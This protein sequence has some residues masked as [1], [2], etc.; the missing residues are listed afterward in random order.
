MAL[1]DVAVGRARR[2]GKVVRVW[3]RDVPYVFNLLL[4]SCASGRKGGRSGKKKRRTVSRPSEMV[5]TNL[6]VEIRVNEGIVEE[7]WGVSDVCGEKDENVVPMP[8][9]LLL[10]RRSVANRERGGRGFVRSVSP[11]LSAVLP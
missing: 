10:C 4:E 3:V 5:P 11:L 7:L 8:R 2:D 6:Q 9:E 1:A